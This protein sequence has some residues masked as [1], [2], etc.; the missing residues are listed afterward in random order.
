M[1]IF[2]AVLI[3]VSLAFTLSACHF[4]GHHPPGHGGVPPG[5]AKKGGWHK[6]PGHGTPPGHRRLDQGSTSGA[7]K[8]Y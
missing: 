3:S 7:P 1:N 4:A 2:K 8:L 5:Q 6:P